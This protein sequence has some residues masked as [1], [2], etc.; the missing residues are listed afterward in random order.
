MK[1][2]K[3]LGIAGSLRKGSYN[4]SMLREAL[5]LLPDNVEMEIF[6]MEGIPPLNQDL[7]DDPPERIKDLKFKVRSAD[8]I[9]IST[10]EY[11][12]SVPG[13]L[14]N[15]IDWVSRAN[16][17]NSWQG[18]P[19]AIMSASTGLI[20]G[21]R[22]QLHL[23]QSFVYLD[24]HAVNRPEVIVSLAAQKFDENGNLTDEHAKQKIRELLVALVE[25]TKK[26]S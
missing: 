16:G 22:A 7:V 15:M 2:V 12:F 21:E 13:V 24:M 6:D 20:G 19:V 5:F 8:A 3:I 11:N 18:K 17:E 23:R 25:L 26:L 14:K 9:L 4:R 1:A 10:P